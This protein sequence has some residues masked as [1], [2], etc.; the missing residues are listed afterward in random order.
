VVAESGSQ[1]TGHVGGSKVKEGREEKRKGLRYGHRVWLPAR[2]G[3]KI[4]L[5]RR[6]ERERHTTLSTG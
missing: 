4:S 6:E 1:R 5:D 3:C 2:I